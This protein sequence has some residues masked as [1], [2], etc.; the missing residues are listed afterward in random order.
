MIPFIIYGSLQVG[1]FFVGGTTGFTLG[2]PITME[3]IKAHVTQYVIGSFVL[4]TAMA[5][6][7]GVGS[8]LLLSLSKKSSN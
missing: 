4:A 8:Y 6:L 5:I 2:T 1:S 3:H 7:F